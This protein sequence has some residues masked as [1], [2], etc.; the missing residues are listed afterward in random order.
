MSSLCVVCRRVE[1]W[2]RE[3][4]KERRLEMLKK[5]ETKRF[6]DKRHDRNEEYTT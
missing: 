3:Y 2:K 4:K 1:R 5:R 6:S